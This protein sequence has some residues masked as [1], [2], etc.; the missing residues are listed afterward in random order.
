MAQLMGTSTRALA[1]KY[2]DTGQAS[3]AD[4]DLYIQNTNEHQSW[5]IYYSTVSVIATR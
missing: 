3:D 1:D 2:V 4:I 5:T